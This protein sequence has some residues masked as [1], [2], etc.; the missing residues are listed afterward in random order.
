MLTEVYV[1]GVRQEFRGKIALGKI[2]K[3]MEVDVTSLNEN[4]A[5]VEITSEKA[6]ELKERLMA[7]HIEKQMPHVPESYL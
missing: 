2:L 6:K 7:C 1:I 3:A 4:F 5:R